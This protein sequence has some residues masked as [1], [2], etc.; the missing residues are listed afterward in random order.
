MLV[1]QSTYANQDFNYP[2]KEYSNLFP[3]FIAKG[4]EIVG[5]DNPTAADGTS[6]DYILYKGLKLIDS[7]TLQTVLTDRF[8][9]FC[10]FEIGDLVSETLTISV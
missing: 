5:I 10:T 9:T 3:E 8:P 6:T 1:L 7:F 2:P 4:L